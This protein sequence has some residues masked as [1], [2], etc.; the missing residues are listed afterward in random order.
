MTNS[1]RSG[2]DRF[3]LD[4]SIAE[5]LNSPTIQTTSVMLLVA[6]IPVAQNNTMAK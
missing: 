1:R 6:K 3:Q 5:T 4:G 2:A